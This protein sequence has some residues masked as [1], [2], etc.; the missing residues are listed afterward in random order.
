MK[1]AM[2]QMKNEGTMQDNLEKSLCAIK[3]AADEGADI[4]LF[5]E[6]QL[7]E[8]F[9]QYHGKDVSAYGITL[10]SKV[11]KAFCKVCHECEIMAA[12][13]I[14]LSENGKF[15]DATILISKEGTILGV[16]KMVHVAQA[17]QFYEQDY[18]TPSDTGF[19]VFETEFGKIG[20]VVCFDRHYPE[21]IRTETLMGGRFDFDSNREYKTRTYENV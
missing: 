16:Q 13:N 5:P 9:P 12:P 7:T 18:Y 3:S 4:I 19:Q 10:E 8:F 14:Y 1:L 21:S 11:I 17:E 15:Y 6:L 2:F 20:I